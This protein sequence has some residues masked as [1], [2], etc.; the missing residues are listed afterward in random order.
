MKALQSVVLSASI[1]IGAYGPS[2]AKE[3]PQVDA[4][5]VGISPSKLERVKSIVQTM[6]EK[7]Q[8]AGAV[9]VVARRGKVALM[10]AFGKM[11]IEANKPMQCD[12]IFRIYS[13]TKPITT[14][15]AMLLV[16]EGKL[17]LDEPVAR[18]LPEFQELRV[19]AGQGKDPV[20]THREM[21]I[22]DLMRHTSGLTYGGMLPNTPLDRI[23]RESRVED[24]G[25]SLADL[26]RKLGKIPLLC[27]P[28]TRFNYSVSTDVLGRIIEIRTGKQLD[29]F[30]QERI[31]KPLDMR[32]TGFFVPDDKVNRFS[33]SYRLG[34]EGQLV[35]QDSPAHSRFRT[36][37]KFLSGG[38]GLVSTARDYLRFCQMILNEGDLEGT[39]L[40]HPETVHL[41]TTDQLPAEAKPM[42]LAGFPLPG[43]GFGL[44]FLLGPGKDP[45]VPVAGEYSWHGAASTS[46]WIA[47]KE[48]LVVVALQQIM[49]F[50]ISFELAIKPVIYGAV[51]H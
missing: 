2:W 31:F 25:D 9:L 4:S 43:Y 18:Y 47:P 33:A 24:P 12:A 36:R 27:E 10:E 5:E 20:A 1:G 19:Y 49:P 30:L 37:P 34:K 48:A 28:S 38:G 7:K 26:V 45:S 32:D 21:T 11:D 14:A 46:F 42:N 35:V 22:R 29:A 13:M 50:S 16:E 39:R 8:T 41:M 23:Y 40:L 51:E 17:Q 3:L 6:V 15:A 44:G